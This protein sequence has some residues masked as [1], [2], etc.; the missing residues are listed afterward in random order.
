MEEQASD[1]PQIHYQICPLCEAS[2]G[3]VIH[4]EGDRIVS[5]GGNKAHL[6]SQ[7][8]IC[9]KGVALQDIRYDPDR[10]LEPMVRQGRDWRTVTWDSALDLVAE[11]LH[12]IRTAHGNDAVAVY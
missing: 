4:T 10:V 11:R 3:L 5:I 8:H 2:C 1:G 6:H 9:P 7:G 12:A